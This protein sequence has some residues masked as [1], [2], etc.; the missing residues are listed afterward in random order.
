VVNQTQFQLD[1]SFA[2]KDEIGLSSS[3]A[4]TLGVKLKDYLLLEGTQGSKE[5]RI[6][7]IIES[8]TWIV[9][10]SSLWTSQVGDELSSCHSSEFRTNRLYVFPKE[11]TAV[12][13]T[14]LL[15]T[16]LQSEQQLRK[17]T[18]NQVLSSVQKG[19]I[20]FLLASNGLGLLS[21]LVLFL[22]D[23]KAHLAQHTHLA[24]LGY[25]QREIHFFLILYSFYQYGVSQAI[26]WVLFPLLQRGMQWLFSSSLAI[27]VDFPSFSY[28]SLGWV[29]G[30]LF[31]FVLAVRLLWI[32][33]KKQKFQ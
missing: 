11:D 31:G 21:Y 20:I 10:Q 30:W 14:A 15:G 7:K 29:S 8:E 33:T 9:Y 1:E 2:G 23:N 6:T 18:M 22:L 4:E 3:L 5:Y 16:F 26:A 27:K 12:Q 28:S 24:I 32:F 19:M 17:H 25:S 13:E